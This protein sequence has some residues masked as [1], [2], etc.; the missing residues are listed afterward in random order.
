MCLRRRNT[1]AYSAR[2]VSVAQCILV[3][4]VISTMCNVIEGRGRWVGEESVSEL[5]TYGT[6]VDDRLIDSN[7]V[8]DHHTFN[9]NISP[10][11]A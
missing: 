11:I 9:P 10:R 6:C 2:I 5:G 4:L 8:F 1:V 3:H 7:E